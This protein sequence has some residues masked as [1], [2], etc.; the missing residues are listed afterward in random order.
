MDCRG[1]AAASMGSMGD[2]MRTSMRWAWVLPL[3]LAVCAAAP[4]AAGEDVWAGP[5]THPP[6]LP[7]PE[8]EVIRVADEAELQRAVAALQSNTTLML[9][10][11]T[12][13]LTNTV[14]IRGGVENVAVRGETG[15]R[16]DVVL[17]GRG[18]RNQD[19]GNVPHG[20]MV[21]NAR[22]VVI[23]DLSVGDVWF[24]PITFQGPAGCQKVRVYNCRLFE[25]GEQFLKS[26]PASP[27]GAKGG[28]DDCRVEY[29]VFEYAGTARHWYTE[30]VDVHAGSRWVVRRNL[31]RNIRG[32]EGA[33]NVGGAVDFWNRSR[34][35]LVEQ[36]VIVNCAVGIRLGVTDRR[37]YD[38]HAGGI[39][40]NNFIYRAK[41]A[42]HWADVGIIVN[43]SANTKVL[44]NT[45]LFED[46][47]P[48][49]IEVRFPA[50]RGVIVAGNLTNR[51]IRR[52]D[53]AQAD[54]ADNVTKASP[55]M[56]VRPAAGDLHLTARA[57]A[58]L[59]LAP[60]RDDC[61]D[62]IDGDARPA[63]RPVTVGADQPKPAE[64]ARPDEA[65]EPSAGT[66][67][68]VE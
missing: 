53:G 66:P 30:G 47:Y 27:D 28:V 1:C 34:D 37:G 58:S 46:D 61:R 19:F 22:G 35:T 68:A 63:G 7:A 8:G 56:F 32:P 54:L 39:V 15:R 20:I 5:W 9:A 3:V 12:Y 52:R 16:D 42:C 10:K 62:D 67:G 48:N 11:G 41:G 26:N 60:A 40:R 29:C 45:I 14:H 65:A 51:A 59:A 24:H 64:S 17:V 57:A 55:G 23:A 21:S 13:R 31:F 2:S 4:A 50:S 49:A 33:K 38:D 43:D 6:P 44:H 18:M 36:N 25:A